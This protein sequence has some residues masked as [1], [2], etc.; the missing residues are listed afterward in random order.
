MHLF[1]EQLH[2]AIQDLKM[3]NG[4]EMNRDL[5]SLLLNF[6]KRYWKAIT[7]LL[8]FKDAKYENSMSRKWSLF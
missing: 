1:Q 7:R 4:E 8:I 3:A 5:L 6:R 2:S